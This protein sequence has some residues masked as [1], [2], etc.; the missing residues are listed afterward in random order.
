MARVAVLEAKTYNS[1]TDS[2]FPN[3]K[4]KAN[5][6][7]NPALDRK[8]GGT[9]QSHADTCQLWTSK[10]DSLL[11][12]LRNSY[13]KPLSNICVTVTHSSLSSSRP[14]VELDS[15]AD[16]CVV[17]DNCIVIHDHNRL[18]NVYCYNEKDGLR[19]AK[20]VDAAVGYQYS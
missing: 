17:D 18:V 2:I 13:V 1:S 4:P 12:V 3:E 20:T 16:M 15:Y 7:N 14:K 19:S 9:R 6:R 8:R 5:N 11:I 10:G